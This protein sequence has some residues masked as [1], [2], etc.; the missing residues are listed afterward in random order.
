MKMKQTEMNLESAVKA[1]EDLRIAYSEYVW[2]DSSVRVNNRAKAALE[3][4]SQLKSLIDSRDVE[5]LE[6]ALGMVWR[7]LEFP[8]DWDR[9][10]NAAS[11]VAKARRLIQFLLGD[12]IKSESESRSG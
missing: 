11:A 9:H 7:A 1:L 12:P 2:T 8:E 4:L 5:L 10:N 3:Y 6:D